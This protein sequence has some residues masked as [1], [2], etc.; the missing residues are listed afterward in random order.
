MP[1]FAQAPVNDSIQNATD[2]AV[3]TQYCS[4]DAAYT[5]V[6]A[7]FQDAGLPEGWT[8]QG[9]D[10]WFKFTATQSDVNIT[11][12]GNSTGGG[13]T[14][15]TL[16]SPLIALYL[17]DNYVSD[18][19]VVGSLLKGSSVTTFYKGGLKVGRTYYIRVSAEN[20]ATGTFSLCINNYSPPVQ[21]GNNCGTAS[22]LCSNK[23]FTQTNISGVG[24]NSNETGN[25]CLAGSDSNKAWYKWQVA[26]NGTLTF[27]ITPTVNTDDID[28]VLYDFGTTNTCDLST[29]IRCAAGH[30][31][32]NTACPTEPLYF[33]TGLNLTETDITEAGGCGQGQNG[34]VKYVDAIAGHYY[35]LLINN[36]TSGNNGFT[37]S[38][39]GTAQFVGPKAAFTVSVAQPCTA[40]Q[41]Y[42]FTNQSTNYSSYLW[43]FGEGA[44]PA[45]LSGSQLASAQVTY[46]SVGKKNR[47]FANYHRHRMCCS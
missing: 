12:T 39:G 41:T 29:S 35:G 19:I 32:D 6:N 1:F 16:T 30:G 28:W 25:T 33:K 34:F 31:V 37:L 36:F 21:P 10:V 14:G 46:N 18:T 43:S 13:T 9:K 11:V 45:T 2:L 5:N 4:G 3:I 47:R 17:T 44:S 15:G 40:G 7:T 20:N 38:F 26:N 23:T 27:V 22:F 42:M 8:S 24:A